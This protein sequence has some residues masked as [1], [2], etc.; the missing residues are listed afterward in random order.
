MFPRHGKRHLRVGSPARMRR[1]GPRPKRVPRASYLAK[2]DELTRYAETS[3]LVEN[4][5]TARCPAGPRWMKSGPPGSPVARSTR[6]C[7]HSVQERSRPHP[8]YVRIKT[9]CN[10]AFCVKPCPCPDNKESSPMS[11]NLLDASS[12]LAAA[13]W[14][15]TS[16]QLV[17]RPHPHQRPPSPR[18][19]DLPRPPWLRA[20]NPGSD[21][22]IQGSAHVGRPRRCRRC[23]PSTSA[24]LRTPTL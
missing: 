17:R 10:L 12:S 18:Y 2:L 15:P 6:R 24:C 16:W 9:G 13:A 11:G 23:R 5:D 14:P 4:E 20:S 3:P 19:P 22:Q 21:Q 8:D 7:S 1:C